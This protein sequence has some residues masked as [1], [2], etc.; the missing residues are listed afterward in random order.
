MVRSFRYVA[1]LLFLLGARGLA[2]HSSSSDVASTLNIILSG[3]PGS[4]EYTEAALAAVRTNGLALEHV[5]PACPDYKKVALA[6]VRENGFALQFVR[7]SL[8]SQDYKEVACVAVQQNDN[9]AKYARMAFQLHYE[10]MNYVQLLRAVLELRKQR[11]KASESCT[12]SSTTNPGTLPGDPKISRWEGPQ[13]G[14]DERNITGAPPGGSSAFQNFSASAPVFVPLALRGA[15]AVRTGFIGPT[16]VELTPETQLGF[17]FQQGMGSEEKLKIKNTSS[18]TVAFKI[19]ITVPTSYSVKPVAGCLLAG[20][21]RDVQ[22]KMK[23]PPA[24]NSDGHFF[25]VQVT[26]LPAGVSP[27][28]KP[29]WDRIEK[30]DIDK[31]FL[32]VADTRL[33]AHGAENRTAHTDSDPAFSPANSHGESSENVREKEME[34]VTV[35]RKSWFRVLQAAGLGNEI[36]PT[37]DEAQ[38]ESAWQTSLLL[39]GSRAYG[40]DSESSDVD[41]AFVL[42]PQASPENPVA[43][44]ERAIG[45]LQ[46]LEQHLA[47][48]QDEILAR[49][50]KN[51]LLLPKEKPAEVEDP[52]EDFAG[53]TEAAERGPD[54]RLWTIREA[55]SIKPKAVVPVLKLVFGGTRTRRIP[56][57][58]SVAGH[59]P[60]AGPMSVE[61][62]RN[63]VFNLQKLAR[64]QLEFS[65]PHMGGV[66]SSERIFFALTVAEF[67]TRYLKPFLEYYDLYGPCWH[68]KEQRATT[69]PSLQWLLM[70]TE[71]FASPLVGRPPWLELKKLPELPEEEEPDDHE[72]LDDNR[73]KLK[74]GKNKIVTVGPRKSSSRG[75][76]AFSIEPIYRPRTTFVESFEQRFEQR[77]SIEQPHQFSLPPGISVAQ[78]FTWLNER[79]TSNPTVDENGPFARHHLVRPYDQEFDYQFISVTDPWEPADAERSSSE[80][81]VD[82]AGFL[83]KLAL[84]SSQL[85]SWRFRMRPRLAAN[86]SCNKSSSSIG[87]YIT[88]D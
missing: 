35:I 67:F 73:K 81:K 88:S 47:E 62:L 71:F 57:D 78:F 15:E 64:M 52:G 66:F 63:H 9:V 10:R 77:S 61:K 65:P 2:V 25:S 6:A 86:S 72:V 74:N 85:P 28:Y 3:S 30:K 4:P 49:V 5:N 80:K 43:F 20:E 18:Q 32:S 54:D 39:F 82:K 48:S 60:G 24:G 1:F 70:L 34:L 69:F 7:L 44:K 87:A 56:V 55:G 8:D 75:P 26:T 79:C 23:H 37:E 19:R 76:A 31:R 22:I 50:S 38:D 84:A 12:S 59:G 36:F 46:K 21:S 17:D 53:S 40:T 27:P 11:A 16:L 41:L 51:L 29:D 14:H 33:A 42:A 13:R 45:I 83:Y 58:L 68:T